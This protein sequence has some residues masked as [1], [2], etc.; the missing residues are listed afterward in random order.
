MTQSI[1]N[2]DNRNNGYGVPPRA[3]APAARPQ[4]QAVRIPDYYQPDEKRNIK[5]ALEENPIYST[6]VKGFF[7][8]L[9]EHPI[10]SLFTWFGC[11]F[12]L[13]KY[14][15]ACGGEY[16]KSLLKK[17]TNFG[18]RLENSSFVQ[19]KPV[20]KV[21]GWFKKGGEK[22][23]SLI[24]KNSVLRAI[25]KTPTMPELELVKS[26]M[27]PQRQRIMHDFSLI[28]KELCLENEKG[29]AK[30]NR[31]ALDKKERELLKSLG[32][33]VN[34]EEKASSYIQLKRL[35][36]KESEIK[37]IISTADGGV[38]RTKS[39]I[40]KAFG[41]KDAA[42]LKSIHGDTI[43]KAEIINEVQDACK[44]VGNKVRI[45]MGEYKPFGFDIG[46][47]TTPTKRIIGCDNIFNRSFS[48]TKD[49]AKTATG[50]FM[51]RFMQMVHRGLTF[52]GGKLGVLL[53]IAPAFVETAINVHK[54]EPN[55]KVG[56]GVS[57]L[58]NHISW[59]FTFPFA[60][61]IMHH[62]CGAKYAGMKEDDIQA[63]RNRVKEINENNKLNGTEKAVFHNYKEW[64]AERESVNKFIKNK[65]KVEGQKWYTK[66]IRKFAGWLTP[67]L[68]KVDAYNTGNII[69]TKFSQMRNLPRNLFGVPAR[70]LLFGVLTM[71]V[72][73]TILNK[74]IKLIFGES[75]DSMKEEEIKDAKKEQKKFLKEDLTD[76]LYE[77]Q[78]R[79]IQ[80]RAKTN[81][82]TTQQINPQG[83]AISHHG[84]VNISEPVKQSAALNT[85][86]GV[87][88]IPPGFND[89]LNTGVRVPS[90]D[91]HN[92]SKQNVDNYTY[93][94]SQ[95]NIIKAEAKGKLDNY[96]YIPSQNSVIES[97]DNKNSA[98]IRSYIPSQMA[99]N[100]AKSWD[101][102][103]LQS[104]LN[105][106][107]RAEQNALRVLAGNFEGM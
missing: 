91:G 65:S 55:Q 88:N 7:G 107:D 26:E 19:S 4:T 40:L 67:D 71:G 18:D 39:E 84:G 44:K 11:G 63:I 64:A 43:G 72:L 52:G 105:R 50:R 106:A 16:D 36:L 90:P 2:F 22:S 69:T 104:A 59:V 1:Q 103:G 85:G 68:G 66:A 37:N 81:P 77:A 49:G 101:N 96:S 86:A 99:A 3:A 94:P 33:I 10:A 21:L 12:L 53:F 75:Y 56:T 54:A 47:L 80:N 9:I 98:N 5:E 35:G 20:Q 95:Q 89:S 46:I 25:W 32:D 61:Q 60:L 34:S 30:L 74:C 92:I 48:L 24:N 17:V 82:Q 97:K 79:K 8:P 45:S 73:D 41:N 102:S 87:N 51:S 58:V 6:V 70:L 13:D 57:N 83:N 31:L 42:W 28:T 62:L 100:I 76:R 93:I 23:G 38:A 15:A 78:R 27:I 29:F 14:T